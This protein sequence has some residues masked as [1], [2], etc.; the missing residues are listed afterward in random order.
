MNQPQVYIT[1]SA[2]FQSQGLGHWLTDKD[3]SFE[4]MYQLKFL[5][6][7]KKKKKLIIRRKKKL[8]IY[9][10]PGMKMWSGEG[11]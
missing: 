5:F 11:M 2:T 10:R 3:L 8:C 9:P 4:D 6:K 1:A 7:S